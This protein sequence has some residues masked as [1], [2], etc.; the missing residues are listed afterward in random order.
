MMRDASFKFCFGAMGCGK[1]AKLRGDYYAK[2]GD[3]FSCIVVKPRL[4]TKGDDCIITRD[5]SK[6]QVTFS[7]D[8]DD[9]IYELVSNY[10][11]D[12]V[13]DYVLVD[14]IQFLE[15]EQIVQ[16]SRIVD[17][18]G[19]SIIGYGII[20]D[21]LGKMFPGAE[22]V[23]CYADDFCYLRRDCSCGRPKIRNMRLVDG[24]PVF[25]GEQIEIDLG[26][27]VT[28]QPVC[29]SCYE[30]ERGKVRIK[31]RGNI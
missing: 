1:T 24:R 4:D 2:M 5:G 10:L 12:N 19:V 16:L 15:V 26:K 29:R 13:L 17:K 31:S 27:E 3:G 11:Y 14:E 9:N 25:E 18:L 20:T 28:Y 22:A 8:K 7:F 6:L 23:F 30:R 21:F